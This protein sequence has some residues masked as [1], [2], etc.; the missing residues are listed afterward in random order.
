[1]EKADAA[2]EEKVANEE[3]DATEEEQKEMGVDV[4]ADPGVGAN[5]E[6]DSSAPDVSAGTAGAAANVS[7]AVGTEV[8]AAEDDVVNTGGGA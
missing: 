3:E 4:N 1:M 2:V 6:T 7:E 5:T 8:A